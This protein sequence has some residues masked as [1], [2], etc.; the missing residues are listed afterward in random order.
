MSHAFRRGILKISS[1]VL[2][3]STT[4]TRVPRIEL[5]VSEKGGRKIS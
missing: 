5:E 3:E 4:L 2:H 1:S